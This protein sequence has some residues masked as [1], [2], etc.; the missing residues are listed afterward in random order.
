[1]RLALCSNDPSVTMNA[2]IATL[3]LAA[4]L[5]LYRAAFDG[6]IEA[7]RKHAVSTACNT[8]EKGK[9][10]TCTDNGVEELVQQPEEWR[11]ALCMTLL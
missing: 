10:S 5:A 9:D 4:C 6:G 8:R 2:K 1:M 7:E 11:E 3:L